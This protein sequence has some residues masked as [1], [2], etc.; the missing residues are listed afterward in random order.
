MT[1]VELVENVRN[2]FPEVKDAGF[3]IDEKLDIYLQRSDTD[4]DVLEGIIMRLY[5]SANDDEKAIRYFINQY[6]DGKY[7]Y[8]T[9]L[10][11]NI[12]FFLLSTAE[13]FSKL[14]FYL[15]FLLPDNESLQVDR[16]QLSDKGASSDKFG[17]AKRIQEMLFQHPGK[18][19]GE[20]QTILWHQPKDKIGGDYYWSKQ[21]KEAIWVAIGD[22]T[23][24]SVEGALATVSILSIINQ[25]FDDGMKPHQLIKKLY[26]SLNNMQHQKL[27][28]GYGIG[29]EMIVFKFNLQSNEVQYSGTGLP[30]YVIGSKFQFLKMK[31]AHFEPD[32]VLRYLR[33][34]RL[35]LKPGTTIFTHSDGLTD[36]LSR[37]GK[38]MGRVRLAEA[39][40]STTPLSANAI[41]Q[42]FNN[43]RE[44]ADQTDDI[45]VF[46]FS[47]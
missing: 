35:V 30:V 21:T 9:R 7:I 36:Q 34:R 31:S 19:L 39:L 42:I 6:N 20:E 47:K 18:F 13:A 45:V 28:E 2:H 38:K 8:C 23:G 1:T 37:T 15:K 3:I 40:R 16:S 5:F 43:W 33:S 17:S 4:P 14:H 24:H 41:S 29:N 46:G 22:C 12:W 27:A 32:R 26:S 11:D 25:I 10:N 44:Q